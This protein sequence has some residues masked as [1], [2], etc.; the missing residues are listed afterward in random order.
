MGGYQAYQWKSKRFDFNKLDIGDN[1]IVEYIWIGGQGQDL[2]S[3]AK[4]VK[5]KV[6]S[7]K[8]LDI[9]NYDGSS[10]GQASTESSEILLIPVALFKDPFTGGNNKLV[11]CETYHCDMQPTNTNF[12]YFAQ[13][14][15]ENNKTK[16]SE[17]ENE[18]EKFFDPWF[19]L[20]QEYAIM[21]PSGTALTWPYGWPQG[22]YPKPQG[23]YYCST[24]IMNNYGR[25]IMNFH[26]KAC[27][28]AGIK[29]QGTN[30]ETMPGQWEF[31]I[32]VCKG[33]EAG[34][35]L[36]MAR[37]ILQRIA[38][39]YRLDINF[40]CK[41]VKGDWNGSGCHVNFSTQETRAEGGLQVIYS[42]IEKLKVTHDKIINLYGEDNKKRLTGK[43]ETADFNNFYYGTGDRKESVSI[44][45]HT[46]KKGKGYYEDRRPGANM[47]PYVVTSA[48][49]AV[50]CLDGLESINE[51]EKHYL[52]FIK[53]KNLK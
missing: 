21:E 28:Y 15:F 33:L 19:G 49:Y 5:G 35:H 44:N 20:E 13:K 31:Q 50:T 40:D 24:G 10:T 25:I 38:E 46:I 18:K 12:R 8:D 30:S 3:K 41:P 39:Y 48:L 17:K 45:L 51:L 43:H 11:F 7:L 52:K 26:Y 34:D 47:D 37:Y 16:E 1:T 27:L 32:G 14:I 4:T 53:E 22:G 23:E 9:W 2:R 42:Q 29:I 36:W 6:N